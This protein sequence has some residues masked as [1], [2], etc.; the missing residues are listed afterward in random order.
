MKTYNVAVAGATGAVGNEMVEILEERNFPVKNLK[1]LASSRSVGKTITFKGEEI[2]VEELKEDSF[3]GIDI[4][5]FSPGGAVSMKFAPIAAASGCVVIDNTSAFRMEPDIPLVV[6]EVNEHAIAGYK[7]RGIISNPNCS[8]IQMVVVLKPLHDYAKIKRIVVSTYQAVSG[9]GKKAIYELEQQVLAIYNN[10]EI[11][12]KVYPHQIAFN[13][14]PHIDSFLENGYT[15]EEMKMVNETK[16][17]MEDPNIQVTATTVRVPVFYGHSES[18]NV[19]FENEIT[20]E[21][22]RELLEKAPGVKVV[23]DP[24]KNLYPLA[25]YA[26]GKDETFVGRIRKDETVKYGLNMW[27]VADNIRKGAALNAVQIAEVLIKKYL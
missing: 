22:A 24:T 3:K 16:K 2:K 11:E 15:K 13:C 9:T 10:K 25:I 4:G 12:K 5:L 23:D 18:V 20:P 14:L 26:A 8:T 6:P 21:K 1:L 17:I 19:E 27:I 7:N